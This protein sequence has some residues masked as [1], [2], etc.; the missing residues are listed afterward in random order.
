MND[1]ARFA[2]NV[3][4]P[5]AF[6]HPDVPID[7]YVR[8]KFD[9]PPSLSA[10]VAHE[11]LSR[12]ALHAKL[13]SARLNPAWAPDHSDV[14]E[15]GTIAH[16]LL[17]ERDASRIVTVNAETWAKK[18]ATDRVA[19]KARDEIRAAGK[20]PIL[21]G[22]RAGVDAMVEAA[23]A[24][25]DAS[26]LAGVFDQGRAESTLMWQDGETWCR[27][28][29]DWITGPKWTAA[30]VLLDYKTV[31]RT[32]EPDGWAR[33]P[34]LSSGHDLQ[35]AFGLAGLRAL[36][37]EREPLFVFLVQETDPPYACSLVSLD[38]PY[39]DWAEAKRRHAVAAWAHCLATGEWPDY[40]RR[41]YYVAPPAWA[42]GNWNERQ[43]LAGANEP[44]GV[45]AL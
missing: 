44:D 26:E 19:W 35:A 36:G 28:R 21:A 14:A 25:I 20:L 11:L 29:P 17:L 1:L 42:V 8:D 37:V 38:K 3:S 27:T 9:T 16:A 31:G 12:S 43:T 6:M 23:R 32:A 13:K 39:L 30:P 7:D 24:Y 41:I 18:D 15:L 2:L 40:G 22:D 45:E 34:L 4:E 10:S 33:G 5:T